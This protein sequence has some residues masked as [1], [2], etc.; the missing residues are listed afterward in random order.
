[1]AKE[2]K[3]IVCLEL[4]HNPIGDG[5]LDIIQNSSLNQNGSI[6]RLSFKYC[7]LK[8]CPKLFATFSSIS[9]LLLLN[10][11]G[12]QLGDSGLISICRALS[13]NI[14]L[15]ELYMKSNEIKNQA[16]SGIYSLDAIRSVFGTVNTTL[17]EL[18]LSLNFIDESG[19]LAILATMKERKDVSKN[20][21]KIHISERVS[22]QTFAKIW[23]LTGST[24]KSKSGK[25]KAKK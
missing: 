21:L 25:K 10:L 11:D 12:N 4:D 20:K 13:N 24:A 14:C 6:K 16:I 19:S 8:D 2:T 22:S 15:E 3:T 18:D 9:N 23:T 17:K 1:V 7:G 5:A